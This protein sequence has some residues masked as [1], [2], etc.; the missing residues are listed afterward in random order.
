MAPSLN[1]QHR[2]HRANR[3]G[4]VVSNENPTALHYSKLFGLPGLHWFASA[5]RN[6]TECCSSHMCIE[7]CI[8]KFSGS[9]SNCGSFR[10]ERKKERKKA[11]RK[12]Q[13]FC[14]VHYYTSNT[15]LIRFSLLLCTLRLLGN[16]VD[17]SIW[18]AF[19]NVNIYR[20]KIS[21]LKMYLARPA[22]MISLYQIWY[23][24]TCNRSNR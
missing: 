18:M 6:I 22:R 17:F 21:P 20:I 3:H 24:D 12:V 23:P 4:S 14:F 2:I 10:K 8:K 11:Q 7:K 13:Y 19:C 15:D 1:S 5:H 9:C 16:I